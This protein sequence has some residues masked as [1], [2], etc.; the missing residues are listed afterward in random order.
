[1]RKHIVAAASGF[2]TLCGLGYFAYISHLDVNEVALTW[3]VI[4]GEMHLRDQ[5]GWTLTPPWVTVVKIDTRPARVCIASASRAIHCKL[6]QFKIAGWQEFVQLEGLRIY[7]FANRISFNGGHDD[8]Y[9]GMRNLL[10]GYT[11][12]RKEYSFIEVLE[13]Q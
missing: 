4:S 1:M 5:Q 2:L 11:F 3:N 9:R 7:W 8:E 6:V 13:E 12:A 10:L